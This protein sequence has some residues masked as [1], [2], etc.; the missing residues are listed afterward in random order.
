QGAGDGHLGPDRHPDQPGRRRQARLGKEGDSQ[1]RRP[2]HESR[3]QADAR[4]PL[5]PDRGVLGLD[6]RP[7]SRADP[8]PGEIRERREAGVLAGRALP[9]IEAP[10]LGAVAAGFHAAPAALAVT[11][12]VQEVP[13]ALRALALADR[14]PILHREHARR[15][16]RRRPARKLGIRVALGPLPLRAPIDRGERTRRGGFAR[17]LR[18]TLERG[19]GRRDTLR[20]RLPE[21]RDRLAGL[22]G[23]LERS[24]RAL[25]MSNGP[26]EEGVSL[27]LVDRSRGEREAEEVSVMV[28][29]LDRLLPS[30][31]VQGVHE[32]E[33]EGAAEQALGPGLI[34]GDVDGN[35][36]GY[37]LQYNP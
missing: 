2:Q 18:E 23:A 25:G 9:M 26:G 36:P 6:D 4:R 24:R 10:R 31:P 37:P 32:V 12:L 22:L 30:S 35:P 33:R 20:Y 17:V 5:G 29:R 34:Q 1:A 21:K 28:Q 3:A 14:R 16:E 27:A 11:R 19:G 8:T 13:A 7:L 15:V